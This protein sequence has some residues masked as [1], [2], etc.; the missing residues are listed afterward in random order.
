MCNPLLIGLGLAAGSAVASSKAQSA[1]DKKSRK[2]TAGVVEA[3]GQRQK[4]FDDKIFN[5][6]G[7]SQGDMR[8]TNVD[9][10]SAQDAM[11]IEMALNDYL[12]SDSETLS[13]NVLPGVG[14]G[15]APRVVQN[16]T[17][18]QLS[19]AESKTRQTNKNFGNLTGFGDALFDITAD[20]N[21]NSKIIGQSGMFANQ[22]AQLVP[23]EL[24]A[25]MSDAQSAGKNWRTLAQVMQLASLATA[26]YGAFG[27]PGAGAAGATGAG[28]QG[29]L[30]PGAANAGGGYSG[31]IA[32]PV[33]FGGFLPAPS[34]FASQSALMPGSGL[35]GPGLG[36][37]F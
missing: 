23:G 17:D 13:A 33:E 34:R 6:A 2:L 35:P 22:S 26:A 4:Q 31:I 19:R 5:L 11:N 7:E 27:G 9:A 10:K 32:K 16:E 20:R 18:R 3:E 14:S 30:M 36:G 15:G 28:G 37:L 29:S 25:A 1:V 12:D 24:Q 21:L 8:R